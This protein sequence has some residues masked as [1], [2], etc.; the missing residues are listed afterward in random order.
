MH[1]QAYDYATLTIVGVLVACVAWPVVTRAS[2]VPRWLFFR[3]AVLVTVGLWLPDL[4]LLLRGEQPRAVGVLMA[5]HLSV[6]LVTYNSLVHLAPVG[7]EPVPRTVAPA[8]QRSLGQLLSE[9]RWPWV[10]MIVLVSVEFLLGAVSLLVLPF[11]RKT[12]FVPPRGQ[13]LF[14][15]HA[16]VG[17]AL[18][19]G[20]LLVFTAWPGLSRLARLSAVIGA[21]GV[22]LGGAGGLL[23]LDH[24]LRLLGAGVMLVGA[25]AAAAAYAVPTVDT[26]AVPNP[27]AAGAVDGHPP[28]GPLG[29]H[30]PVSRPGSPNGPDGVTGGNGHSRRRPTS[31]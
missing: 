8:G 21:S 2:S 14:L 18:A 7:G 24:S 12:G 10:T 30:G 26:P 27:A 17:F 22:L 16:G 19:G 13:M 4:W 1:F 23:S 5:M 29:S 28:A 20:A 15:L 6:A 11:G 31:S 25:V 3:M 9:E